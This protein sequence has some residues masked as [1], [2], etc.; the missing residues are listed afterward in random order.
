MFDIVSTQV[1]DISTLKQHQDDRRQALG[2]VSA[3][4]GGES[5]GARPPPGKICRLAEAEADVDSQ[6]EKQGGRCVG[7]TSAL[8]SWTPLCFCAKSVLNQ[9]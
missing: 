6:A 5:F 1:S 4:G 3:P 9:H 2:V 7:S 8:A